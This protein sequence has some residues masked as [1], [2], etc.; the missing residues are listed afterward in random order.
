MEDYDKNNRVFCSIRI[1]PL[2]K[3]E[4]V[5]ISLTYLDI[6]IL[7]STTHLLHSSCSFQNVSINS[8]L[9]EE[10][11]SKKSLFSLF[12]ITDRP[13]MPKIQLKLTDLG[14]ETH[15]PKLPAW[16]LPAR[17]QSK[18]SYLVKNFVKIICCIL[19]RS[20]LHPFDKISQCASCLNINEKWAYNNKLRME[21]N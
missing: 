15:T 12:P 16:I 13:K 7:I 19:D 17:S 2:G 9:L 21:N 1:L 20:F 4:K 6:R 3:C 10:A 11:F 18:N 5:L 8:F 14:L